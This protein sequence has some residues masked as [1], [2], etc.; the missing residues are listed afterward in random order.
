[1][2]LINKLGCRTAISLSLLLS[3]HQKHSQPVL[4]NMDETNHFAGYV[5]PIN[6]TK[7]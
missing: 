7:M 2:F 3:V 1:M 6:V 4:I 5:N